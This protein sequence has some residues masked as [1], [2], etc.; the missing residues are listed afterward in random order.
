[1]NGPLSLSLF[2]LAQE[3][4]LTDPNGSLRGAKGIT[5]QVPSSVRLGK[6]REVLRKSGTGPSGGGGGRGGE[7][8]GEEDA[9]EALNQG[10]NSPGTGTQDVRVVNDTSQKARGG[11]DKGEGASQK[12]K[13]SGEEV[14]DGLIRKFDPA[15]LDMVG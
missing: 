13:L 2:L 14:I 5:S 1:M 6:L 11:I 3:S 15:H 10:R 9:G 12:E 7:E 8:G 4:A